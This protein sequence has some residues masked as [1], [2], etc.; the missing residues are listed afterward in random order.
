MRGEET[1]A[2]N[3]F[4][5]PTVSQPDPTDSI[6]EGPS[7]ESESSAQAL[8]AAI[9]ES[10][11]DAIISKSIHGIITSWNRS[12]ERLFGYT[13]KEAIG[14]HISLIIPD[15][16]LVE[17]DTIIGNIREGRKIEH[18]ET[19]RRHKNGTLLDI[20]LTVSPIRDSHG[21]IIGASKLARDI[22]ERKRDAERQVLLLR[23]MNHRIKNI[24]AVVN[25]VIG[26]SERNA[27]STKDLATDLRA[28]TNALAIAHELTLPTV[29]AS[30]V[31]SE[32]T[33]IFALVR[34]LFAAHRANGVERV[35]IRGNN[36]LLQGHSLTSL[37]LLLHEFSTNA[38]KYGALS[39]IHGRVE[40]EVHNHEMLLLTWT[41]IGGPSVTPNKTSGF[42]SQ[43]ERATI[44]SLGGSVEREWN[45]AGLIIKLTIPSNALGGAPT[46]PTS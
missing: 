3:P 25:A 34:A 2:D 31:R 14:Q 13:P 39:S 24:F 7:N 26:L 28:R 46:S 44:N 27:T 5:R 30:A 33:T 38:V 45:P 6:L 41:E 10:S 16:R 42:G 21:A 8:L 32:D 40:I 1:S 23:E 19:V 43:L 29:G 15:D 4:E 36:F 20:S 37:A 9:V 22:S 17:E 11:D 35:S 12:A 18:Y